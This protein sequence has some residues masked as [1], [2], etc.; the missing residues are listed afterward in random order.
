MLVVSLATLIY[1]GAVGLLLLDG[2]V[3]NSNFLLYRLALNISNGHGLVYNVGD[4][5]LATLS[6]LLAFPY[7][8]APHSAE[9]I[10][11]IFSIISYSLAAGLIYRLL[12]RSQ[13]S[14][15]EATGAV[16]LWL[17]AWSTMAGFGSPS[18]IAFLLAL[19][20]IETLEKDRARFAGLVMGVTVLI[21]PESAIALIAIGIYTLSSTQSRQYW[22]GACIPI[23]LWAIIA[24]IV[25]DDFLPT[26]LYGSANWQD[27]LFIALFVAAALVFY[28]FS[29]DRILWIFPLWGAGD[30]LARLLIAGEITQLDNMAIGVTIAIA[31]MVVLR[32]IRQQ[33]YEI[34]TFC[35]LAIASLALT[36]IASPQTDADIQAEIDFAKT[37][38]LPADASIAIEGS[39]AFPYYIAEFEGE[40][41][42]LEATR[43]SQIAEFLETGDVDSLLVWLA[44]DYL[45]LRPS[46]VFSGV[47]F[48]SPS[49]A[50]L[51]Y[52]AVDAE[53]QGAYISRHRTS[54]IGV[55]GDTHFV[56]LD[57]GPDVQLVSYAVD[58]ERVN[59]GETIRIRLDWRL[60]YAPNLDE[61]VGLN[62]SLLDIEQFPSVTI[63]PTLPG[64]IWQPLNVRTYHALQLP[65]ADILRGIH[66]ITVSVD[67]RAG[68]LGAHAVGSLFVELP[69]VTV[70]TDEAIGQLGDVILWDAT[71]IEDNNMLAVTVIW[72]TQSPLEH[73]YQIFTHLSPIND[74]Q[75]VSQQDGQPLDGR[76]PI[77]YWL[78]GQPVQTTQRVSIA[79]VTAGEYR[80]NAGLFLADGGRLVGENGDFVTLAIVD[81][82]EAGNVEISPVE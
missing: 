20:A 6:P 71:V 43:S 70:E 34:V 60:D 5:A 59:P 63:F 26:P 30:I 36:A 81:I 76:Y 33:Q 55:F 42:R 66:H 2:Y 52:E 74:L 25:Y 23:L 24:V 3:I 58:N 54:H 72:E 41:F 61:S 31:L 77:S 22:L 35:G 80:I 1:A 4:H 13:F 67:Y 49:L 39:D 82:D 12:R 16:L 68:L 53:N 51:D 11:F 46:G 9:T 10:A 14:Q 65:E 57:F 44:P 50:A 15:T 28:R 79:N 62:V 18:V 8:I 56:N 48:L 21:Q 40:V 38:T 29:A 45:F 75:P 47:D 32:F 17:V 7:A 37:L 69:S 73:D 19:C 78:P 64:R 27:G